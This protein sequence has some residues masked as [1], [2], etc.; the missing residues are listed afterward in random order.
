[1]GIG[2]GEPD[3]VSV[4]R[5]RLL[6]IVGLGDAQ[7]LREPSRPRLLLAQ[8]RISFHGLACDAS[9]L[10]GFRLGLA[11]AE[12]LPAFFGVRGDIP[13]NLFPADFRPVIQCLLGE[14]AAG[15]DNEPGGEI[16][17][18]EGKAENRRNQEDGRRLQPKM[19]VHF[20]GGTGKAK[21]SQHAK[22]MRCAGIIVLFAL[23][24]D[25]A[26]KGDAEMQPIKGDGA[27][28]EN[29]NGAIFAPKIG[30]VPRDIIE[31]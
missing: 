14:H 20:H 31:D 9:G 17:L 27:C 29:A 18:G 8:G 7:H 21:A 10:R 5:F 16:R 1:M 3:A 15:D 13:G 24:I 26:D 25:F 28:R 2:M 19:D 23:T 30:F 4:V 6:K 22:R 12:R 11:A